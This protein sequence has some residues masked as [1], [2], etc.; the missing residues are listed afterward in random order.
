L[1]SLFLA[2]V[3]SRLFSFHA[4]PSFIFAQV[5]HQVLRLSVKAYDAFHA[6]YRPL[7]LRILVRDQSLN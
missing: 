3:T 1:H 5:V 7:L 2:P 4:P 6:Q